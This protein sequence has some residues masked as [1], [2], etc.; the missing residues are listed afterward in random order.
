MDNDESCVICKQK[1]DNGQNVIKIL[2][3][4]AHGI[5]EA[6]RSRKSDVVASVGT[7]VH[8]SCRKSFTDKK[9]I[10]IL[11]RKANCEEVPRKSSRLIEG[12]VSSATHCLFC[13]KFV[14]F[15]SKHKSK[16]KHVKVRTTKCVEAIKQCYERHC[17]ERSFKVKGRLAYYLDDLIA[18]DCVYHQ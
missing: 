17:D 13:E 14:D 1:I 4:G 9:N 8:N 6:S 5:N 10:D 16:S 7:C 15:F 2:Q 3:K 18:A 12:Q 11:K